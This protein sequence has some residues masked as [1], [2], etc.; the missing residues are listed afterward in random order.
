MHFFLSVERHVSMVRFW[1][2]LVNMKSDRLT[3]R[4]FLWDYYLN[5]NNWI[6]HIR[7]ILETSHNI[8]NFNLKQECDIDN[9]RKALK[10]H[11]IVEWKDNML[12]KPKLR[13]YATF[14]HSFGTEI[15]VSQTLSRSRRSYR[16]AQ[17]RLG[18]ISLEIDR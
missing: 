16:G 1:N 11:F 17:L 3:K 15:Y 10:D 13:T 12:R 9:V 18:V 8:V 5:Q 14:K 4:I 6:S 7:T 2:K